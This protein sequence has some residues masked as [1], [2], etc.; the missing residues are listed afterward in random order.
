MAS[1]QCLYSLFHAADISTTAVRI[2][3]VN[4]SNQ[5]AYQIRMK[6]ASLYINVVPALFLQSFNYLLQNV[7]D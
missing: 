6:F 5:L 4:L 7:H 3:T 2:I 1:F